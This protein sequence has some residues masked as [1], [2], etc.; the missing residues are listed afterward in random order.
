[1]KR[2]GII[3]GSICLMLCSAWG[4]VSPAVAQDHTIKFATIA[5]D[6]STWMNVMRAYD[7]AIRKESGGRLGFKIYPGGVQGEDKD[8]IKKI[9]IGQIHS[10]GFT[11]VGLGEIA[12]KVRIL[13]SP[14]LCRNYAEVDHLYENLQG[15][16]EQAFLDG[17]FVL[18]GWAEVGFVYVF[19]NTPVRTVSDMSGVKMWMWE[20]DPVAE[21]TFKTFGI[22]PIPLS[23]V[24]VLT[25]L[26]TGLINGA[27]VSP[28]AAVALQWNTRVRY[29][30]GVPLADA[31]G[32]VVISRKKFD[33]IPP[34]LREIL[35][36]NGKTFLRELTLK[37]RAENKAAIETLKK[38]GIQVVEV[39]SEK[40]VTEYNRLGRETRQALVGKLYDEEFLSR[41]EG[42]LK[43]FRAGTAGSK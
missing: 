17:G 36:R 20:G 34:D 15:E 41:V 38:N 26:Q 2:S 4:L 23:V 3:L 18:L 29:M 28:Y 11:G 43:T 33:S 27:Y 24:D 10:A 8:V 1:M 39:S 9:R 12:P 7:E 37:S 21:A 14:F 5:P 22:N 13:D 42:Q 31:C 19:S 35:L 16:F 40:T 32:A 6:G 25:S 30:M